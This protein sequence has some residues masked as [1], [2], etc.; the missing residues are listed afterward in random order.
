MTVSAAKAASH[1][2]S[3]F[4]SGAL[5]H[6]ALT[7]QKGEHTAQSCANAWLQQLSIHLSTR[8]KIEACTRAYATGPQKKQ[9]KAILFPLLRVVDVHP[10]VL[11]S[12]FQPCSPADLRVPS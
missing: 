12:I 2:A 4:S 10:F 8:R 3:T 1:P 6:N 5:F 9:V 11:P 7:T